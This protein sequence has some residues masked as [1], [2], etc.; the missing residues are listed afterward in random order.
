MSLTLCVQRKTAAVRAFLRFF[1]LSIL[2]F[3]V[4]ERYLQRLVSEPDSE[5]F[6]DTLFISLT[7]YT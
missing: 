2:A 5:V 7:D 1:R 6:S 4:G 3:E